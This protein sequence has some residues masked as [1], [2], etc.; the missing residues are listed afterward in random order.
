MYVDGF[1]CPVAT[2]DREHY[3]FHAGRAALLFR[4][5]GALSITECWGDDVPEGKVDPMRS[6]VLCE[7]NETVVFSRIIRPSK[8]VRERG[9][10]AVMRELQM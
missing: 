2:V 6:A 9:V 5:H 1:M 4:K 8:E 7:E 3:R 10:A